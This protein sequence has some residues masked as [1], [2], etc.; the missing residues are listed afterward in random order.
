ML[1]E[2]L[3]LRVSTLLKGLIRRHAQKKKRKKNITVFF[4]VY[5]NVFSFSFCA[6]RLMRPLSKKIRP[7]SLPMTTKK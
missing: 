6:C 4:A 2:E 1:C 3:S 7:I 5:Y